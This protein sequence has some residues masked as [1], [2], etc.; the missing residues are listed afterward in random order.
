MWGARSRRRVL[1]PTKQRLELI[2]HLLVCEPSLPV[3]VILEEGNVWLCPTRVR[4]ELIVCWLEERGRLDVLHNSLARADL[5]SILL[6]VDREV[7][8]RRWG[9][10]SRVDRSQG[11]LG[12]VPPCDLLLW[13]RRGGRHRGE[14]AES[15]KVRREEDGGGAW[16]SFGC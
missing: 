9:T 13:R 3:K 7:D 11:G 14:R 6:H 15:E 10:T 12:L 2:A 5:S 16:P 8:R 1:C 4:V